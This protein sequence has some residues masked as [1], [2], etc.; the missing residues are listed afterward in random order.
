MN[1]FPM[2]SQGCGILKSLPTHGAADGDHQV[3]VDMHYHTVLV[4]MLEG[5]Q[6]AL[7]CTHLGDLIIQ[8][9]HRGEWPILELLQLVGE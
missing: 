2:L 6:L 1:P 3:L 4:S 8:A 5:A 7:G 9:G